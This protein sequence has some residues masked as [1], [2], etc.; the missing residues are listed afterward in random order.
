MLNRAYTTFKEAGLN[1]LSRRKKEQR[2]VGAALCPDG[3]AIAVLSRSSEDDVSPVLE[4]AAQVCCSPDACGTTLKQMVAGLNL[5]NAPCVGVMP[6]GSYNLMQTELPA[7]PADELHDAV[8]WQIRDLLDF[9]PDEAVIETIE[10]EDTAN[11]RPLSFA[12]AAQRHRIQSLV[13]TVRDEGGLNLRAV[14]IPELSLRALLHQVEGSEQ[15]IALLILWP[16]EGMVVIIR[17]EDLC[18]ARKVGI[19]LEALINAA[20]PQEET[21]V[22]IS[23]AQQNL[24]DD[25]ILDI[26]R[27]L[28]FYE[29]NVS[30]RPVRKVLIAPLDFPLPGLVEYLDTYL[31]P[32]VS[33][34]DLNQILDQA[35]PRAENSDH[36]VEQINPCVLPAI[37]AALRAF[38]MLP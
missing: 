11:G 32:E 9:P 19:G 38:E 24:L 21:G 14:D 6:R 4:H 23:M 2:C 22:D 35:Y 7:V 27:S 5:G 28:D 37:G 17:G 16:T 13:N 1:I 12:V 29:S 3:M 30:R 26:Q 20:E 15:G 36:G 31:N 10:F 25:A 34:L 18:M 33:F 8:R